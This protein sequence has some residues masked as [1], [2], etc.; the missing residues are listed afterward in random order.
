M[1][2]MVVHVSRGYGIPG[3][4]FKDESGNNPTGEFNNKLFAPA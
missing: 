4:K 2:E 3:Y 1:G